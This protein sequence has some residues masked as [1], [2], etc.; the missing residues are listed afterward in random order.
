MPVTFLHTNDFHG[1]LDSRKADAIRAMKGEDTLY[2]DSGDCIKCGNLGIPTRP[3][4]AWGLLATAGC[5]ASVLGNRET[6]LIPAAFRAK[7]EGHVHPVLCGNLHGKDGSTPLPA[8]IQFKAGGLRIVVLAV[9]VPMVTARM[10]TQAASAYLWDPPIETAA[11]LAAEL[12]KS[13]DVVVALTH[14]GHRQDRALAEACPEI[15]LIFGGH[16]HTVLERPERVGRTWI[17]Q[18]GSHGRYVGRY[19]GEAGRLEGGL[20]SL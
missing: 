12:R 4:K 5:D 2:F 14:I 1:A 10:K 19:A 17:C 18:G 3:E 8:T 16:S 6:H 11:R 20:I 9:M 15:D 7:L 13:A